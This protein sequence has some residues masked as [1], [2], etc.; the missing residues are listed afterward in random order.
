MKL[1]KKELEEL[2]FTLLQDNKERNKTNQKAFENGRNKLLK[3]L[4]KL[5]K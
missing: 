2:C 3:E 5:E 4:K 1:L